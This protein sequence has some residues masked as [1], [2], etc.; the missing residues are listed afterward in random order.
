MG[1]QHHQTLTNAQ[2]QSSVSDT[3]WKR[4]PSR[5][6]RSGQARLLIGKPDGPFTP[7][8][9]ES[10]CNSEGRTKYSLIHKLCLFCLLNFT[11]PAYRTLSRAIA[12]AY[13]PKEQETDCQRPSRGISKINKHNMH[14]RWSECQRWDKLNL[15]RK[16]CRNFPLNH[17]KL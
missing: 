12:A 6:L 16:C 2:L 11:F 10:N 17:T 13:V 8:A 15:Q 9:R 14:I 1:P 5:A 4:S 3:E 7:T